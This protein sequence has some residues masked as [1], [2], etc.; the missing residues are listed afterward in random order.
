MHEDKTIVYC[1]RIQNVSSIANI[2]ILTMTFLTTALRVYLN[3]S[4][5]YELPPHRESDIRSQNGLTIL[6]YVSNSLTMN[7]VQLALTGI[8]AIII[9]CNVYK[10]TTLPLAMVRILSF[11]DSSIDSKRLG[12]IVPGRRETL[13]ATNTPK[14]LI[15]KST[16]PGRLAR[17][18]TLRQRSFKQQLSKKK[19]VWKPSS[20]ISI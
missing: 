16:P 3:A 8:P 17:Q 6:N 2:V 5:R 9:M 4:T 11:I 13:V 20:V 12:K 15:R 10:R 19:K 1:D 18:D 7:L 14:I